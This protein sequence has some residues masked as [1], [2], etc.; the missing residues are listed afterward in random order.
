MNERDGLYPHHI[1]IA[2]IDIESFMVAQDCA[3]FLVDNAA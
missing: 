3:G 1:L 2:I